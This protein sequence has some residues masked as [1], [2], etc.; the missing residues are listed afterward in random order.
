MAFTVI[1]F[2]VASILVISVI[3]SFSF[4]VSVI[5]SS[6]ASLLLNVFSFNLLV[7]VAMALPSVKPDGIP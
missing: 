7:A 1:I 2:V 4:S 3:T 6:I 5:E